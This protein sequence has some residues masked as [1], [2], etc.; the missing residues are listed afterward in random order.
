MEV[1]SA[2][3][4]PGQK[5]VY[6]TKRNQ[7]GFRGSQVQLEL[8]VS[9]SQTLG[10]CGFALFQ[11]EL[12]G[13]D[14][15]TSFTNV[16]GGNVRPPAEAQRTQALPVC[17][18]AR[19]AVPVQSGMRGLRKDSVSRAHSENGI[20]ARGVLPRRGRVRHADGVHPG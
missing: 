6:V 10:A 9:V 5:I 14:A 1:R 18:D 3:P 2:F 7:V 13:E 17:A 20:V 11:L 4:V 12:S 15:G 8:V 16:D 19:A